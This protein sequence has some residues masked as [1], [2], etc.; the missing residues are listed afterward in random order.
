MLSACSRSA[1]V[2]VRACSHGSMF[3]HW[4]SESWRWRSCSC[5]QEPPPTGLRFRLVSS[6]FHFQS[7]E[8]A[9]KSSSPDPVF[10]GR[11][12][13]SCAAGPLSASPG[14]AAAPWRVARPVLLRCGGCRLINHN[15]APWNETGCRMHRLGSSQRGYGGKCNHC[16]D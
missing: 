13:G 1:R 14:P 15:I 9:S 16:H 11:G 12:C 10:T 4:V 7:T 3:S 8:S 6:C 2:A 5:F